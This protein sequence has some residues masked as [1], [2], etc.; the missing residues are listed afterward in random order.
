VE[1]VSTL[2]FDKLVMTVDLDPINCLN[3]EPLL[4]RIEVYYNREKG[5]YY[6]ER[7]RTEKFTMRQVRDGA[8]GH[9]THGVL[10]KDFGCS[11]PE[12]FKG[13]AHEVIEAV[14]VNL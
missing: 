14:V 8:S 7:W 6:P 11:G 5:Y 9:S 1:P 12:F 10:V 3:Y 2:S 4:M 13:T